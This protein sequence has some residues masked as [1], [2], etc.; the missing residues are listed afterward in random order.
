MIPFILKY[1]PALSRFLP[2]I[3]VK[4]ILFFTGLL[5]SA[6]VAWN[7]WGYMQEKN[8]LDLEVARQQRLIEAIEFENVDR[9]RD[10]LTLHHNVL[11]TDVDDDRFARLGL[12][13]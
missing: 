11:R 7:V 8:A 2:A 3:S 10:N 9:A 13:A 6:F 12:N 5:L 1:V 4:H